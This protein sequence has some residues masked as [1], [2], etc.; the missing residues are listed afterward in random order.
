MLES[1][2]K[3]FGSCVLVWNVKWSFC[4]GLCKSIVGSAVESRLWVWDSSSLSIGEGESIVEIWAMLESGGKSFGSSVLVWHVKWS[5]CFG[6]CKSIV[7]SAVE[8][9]LWV[10]DSSGLSIS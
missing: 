2:G 5:F 3:S 4:F 8:S 7:G 9:T 10:W 6:L 1:V